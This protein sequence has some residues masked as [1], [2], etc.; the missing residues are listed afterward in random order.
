M[1]L[2]NLRRIGQTVNHLAEV[3]YF[4]RAAFV[5]SRQK[6]TSPDKFLFNF[7]FCTSERDFIIL[8]APK[9]K[10]P[11]RDGWVLFPCCIAIA[12]LRVGLEVCVNPPYTSLQRQASGR[13]RHIGAAASG[14]ASRRAR[15]V[16]RVVRC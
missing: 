6:K 16:A 11:F 1:L 14:G 12:S 8:T 7:L 3:I 10:D 4:E 9:N 13:Y 5:N 2:L 15:A